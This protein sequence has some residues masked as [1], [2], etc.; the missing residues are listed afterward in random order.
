VRHAIVDGLNVHDSCVHNYPPRWNA[1]SQDLLES[2]QSPGAKQP[3]AIAMKD[4]RPFGMAM[5]YSH[6][7]PV[8]ASALDHE[9]SWTCRLTAKGQCSHWTGRGEGRQRS[10]LHLIISQS[11]AN[12]RQRIGFCIV[13]PKPARLAPAV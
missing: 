8:G 9:R 3:Y 6:T 4:G 1:A 5:H 2:L 11:K 10:R 12:L 13:V 7:V